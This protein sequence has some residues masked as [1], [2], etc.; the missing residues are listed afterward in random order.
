MT[1]SK[2]D[3]DCEV[4]LICPAQADQPVYIYHELASD[5]AVEQD[6]SGAVLAEWLEWLNLVSRV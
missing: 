1:W 4:R 5:Y 3:A 2:P 6:V